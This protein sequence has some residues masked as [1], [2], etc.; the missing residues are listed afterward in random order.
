VT[1]S[2]ITLST[3]GASGCT[4]GFGF[5]GGAGAAPGGAGGGSTGA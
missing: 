4:S 2:S 5:R 3:P 1:A